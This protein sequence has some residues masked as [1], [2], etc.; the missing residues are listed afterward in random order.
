MRLDLSSAR[1][2]RTWIPAALLGAALAGCG[3]GSEEKAGDAPSAG[4]SKPA[5]P[6]GAGTSGAM[7]AKGAEAPPAQMGGT[8]EIDLGKG[9]VE[10]QLV[11]PLA[12]EVEYE[13]ASDKPL[14]ASFPEARPATTTRPAIE[15]LPA[16]DPLLGK[17]L[18][19]N[20]KVVPFEEVKRQ[21]CLGH[22]GVAEIETAKLRIYIEE[23]VER[24][25][26]AGEKEDAL[27]V[28]DAELD[29]HLAEI[30]EQIKLE[31][32][33][34]G[35]T[36]QDLFATLGTDTPKER[37]RVS[38]LFEKL[39]LP[40]DPAQY[41]PVTIEAILK[42]PGGEGWLEELKA[43][44]AEQQKLEAQQTGKKKARKS[45]DARTLTD[46]MLQQ[47]VEHLHSIAKLETAPAPGVLY[48]LNGVDITV[49]EVWA[50]I[51]PLITPME[52]H[53]A[54][55]WIV[56]TVLLRQAFEAA[57]A[58]LSDAEAE[59]AYR[60]H[61]DPYKDSI[62]S[63]ER[64]ALAVKQFPSVDRYKEYRRLYES[65]HRMKKGEITP[66]ALKKQG[67]YRTN[68]I[69]GQV[70][71]D[72]DVILCSAMDLKTGRWK[73]NGWV[74]AENRMR[75]VLQLLVEEQQPW[76]VMVEKYSDFYEQP[77]PVSER[78]QAEQRP[79][80][81]RFRGMQRNNM[82]VELGES[83]YGLF[84]NG[85]SITDFIFYEQEVGTLGQP[86]RGP[87]GWYLPRLIRRSLP[88]R[89]LAS[90]EATLTA[91]TLD[92]YLTWNLNLLVQELI[93]KNEVYGLELPGTTPK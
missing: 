76:E 86:M 63:Y 42:S 55:Q 31:Y 92:D 75:D 4:T 43:N 90:D 64:I 74:E 19:I 56:N 9:K 24:R 44:Y 5:A 18:V 40:D 14:T 15:S 3:G 11:A 84:L 12:G 52:V 27:R 41:P 38:R 23:E 47:V 73:P 33:E 80:K 36:M 78:E 71:V 51:Q 85:N 79:V 37:L 32:P 35:V 67:E 57:G 25:V 82:L 28:G 45:L 39:F 68:K 88:P 59:A 65:F 7:V 66:E 69:V 53:A 54:K 48:R 30:E 17:P 29:A 20:G 46:A 1:L 93:R 22:M 87:I 62:F 6:S 58:W 89:Q 70:T 77:V 34:G 83:E 26:T 16:D 91:L 81:G 49:A 60:A 8:V 21:V 2:A 61:S 50:R 13:V 72:A 10:G